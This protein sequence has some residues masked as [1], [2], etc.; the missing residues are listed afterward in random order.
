MLKGQGQGQKTLESEEKKIDQEHKYEL[1][2]LS[3]HKETKF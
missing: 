2:L 3:C 1:L